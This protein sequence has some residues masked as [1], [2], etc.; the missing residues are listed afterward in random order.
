MLG[1][2]ERDISFLLILQLINKMADWQQR[3]SVGIFKIKN[4]VE[5]VFKD[6]KRKESYWILKGNFSTIS[7]IWRENEIQ[8]MVEI[9]FNIVRY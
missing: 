2:K 6:R 7:R 4:V 9:S 1:E 3:K 5:K 8:H